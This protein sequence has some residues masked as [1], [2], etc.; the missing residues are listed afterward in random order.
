MS[1]IETNPHPQPPFNSGSPQTAPDAVI[2]SVKA[3]SQNRQDIRRQI[4]Q[5]IVAQL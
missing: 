2:N 1:G 4:I 3:A 5:K